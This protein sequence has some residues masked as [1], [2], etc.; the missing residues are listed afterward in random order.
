M[1]KITAFMTQKNTDCSTEEQFEALKAAVK[2]AA[3]AWI[4]FSVVEKDSQHNQGQFS[5]EVS[6][7]SGPGWSE[8]SPMDCM[9]IESMLMNIIYGYAK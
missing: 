2:A 4:A 5:V 1:I 9:D 8:M 6:C 7:D 3:P